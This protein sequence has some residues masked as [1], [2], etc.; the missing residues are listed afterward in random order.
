MK[1]LVAYL[2]RLRRADDGAAL[3]EFALVLPILLL[4]FGTIMEGSRTFWSYQATIAGVRDATRYVGR[5]EQTGICDGGSGSLAGWEDELTDI[6]RNASDGTPLFPSTIT[7]AR[8]TPELTCVTG[9][10]R[11]ARVPMATVTAELRITYPFAGLFALV[12]LTLPTVNT[13]VSDTG[14]IFGA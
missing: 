8:V 11:L 14:R 1:R 2:A 4:I 13:V 12:G 6:V 3:V 5:S 10:Y 7:V 9:N